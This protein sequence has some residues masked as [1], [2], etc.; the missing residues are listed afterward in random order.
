MTDLAACDIKYLP[1]V[2][3]QRAAM[4][5]KEAGICTLHDL[6]Y[7]FPYKYVDRS[8]IYSIR[9]LDGSMPYIQLKGEIRRFEVAGEGRHRR[10]IAHFTDGT[11]F[12]DLVW[13]QGIKYLTGKYKV[14]Q[15]YIVFGRPT[16]YNGRINIAHP[17]IDLVSEVQMSS[18]GLRPYYNTTEKMKRSF[19][20]SNAIEKLVATLVRKR[21]G[22]VHTFKI[23]CR[24]VFP[25][26]R[27]YPHRGCAVAERNVSTDQKNSWLC[28][29]GF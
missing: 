18:M 27:K 26:L 3:P 17:D 9:E 15:E 5:N 2:G 21:G 23:T 13:F 1:G 19:L 12:V 11:G 29:S 22:K 7:Y 28:I 16:A 6:L 10:L 24:S 25:G 14:H 4:L 8:R 20:N